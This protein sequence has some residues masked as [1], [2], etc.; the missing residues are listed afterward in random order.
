MP[1]PSEGLDA[2]FLPS[3]GRKRETSN[4][5]FCESA[6]RRPKAST[7]LTPRYGCRVEKRIALPLYSPCSKYRAFMRSNASVR[8]LCEETHE[9]K[10][11]WELSQWSIQSLISYMHAPKFASF[12]FYRRYHAY[13][14]IRTLSRILLHIY[15]I[16]NHDGAFHYFRYASNY[17]MLCVM[18]SLDFPFTLFFIYSQS[19]ILRF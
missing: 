10:R 4:S 12:T 2:H 16:Y 19:I 17:F 3:A 7:A 15:L 6:K 18:F 8:M 13:Q 9:S 1:I 14:I 11:T 5:I